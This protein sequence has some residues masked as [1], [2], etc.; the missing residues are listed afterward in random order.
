[1]NT[2][3]EKIAHALN[4]LAEAC[5]PDRS[6]STER[7]FLILGTAFNGYNVDEM[8]SIRRDSHNEGLCYDMR[9][10]MA[11]KIEEQL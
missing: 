4:I 1:M 6:E 10:P 11:E 9:W 8:E 3:T 2:R 7:L 5:G